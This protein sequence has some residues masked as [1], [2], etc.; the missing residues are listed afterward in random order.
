VGCFAIC[1]FII[2]ASSVTSGLFALGGE[3]VAPPFDSRVWEVSSRTEGQEYLLMEWVLQGEKAAAWTELISAQAFDKHQSKFP[4][5]EAAM[6]QLKAV[7]RLRCPETI[8]QVLERR[9]DSILYEWRTT[10][11]A[12]QPMQ[13]Q[14]ARIFDG[15]K[16]RYRLAYTAKVPELV[17]DLRQAWIKRFAALKAVRSQE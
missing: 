15:V 11:C 7:M 14:I 12:V 17:P 5:P 10:P 16:N 9:D 1:L 3:G 13:H 8:W 2:G 6:E 4:P